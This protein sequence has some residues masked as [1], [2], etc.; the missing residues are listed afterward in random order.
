MFKKK[1]TL[2]TAIAFLSTALLVGCTNGGGGEDKPSGGDEPAVASKYTVNYYVDGAVYN[3]VNDVEK[4]SKLQAP[5]DPT[6]A[7]DEDYTYSFDGWYEN[8]STTKWN[9]E[10][11]TVTKNLDLYAKFNQSARAY[12]LV[13]WVWGGTTTVYITQDE[14][15]ALSTNATMFPALAQKQV[16]WK[17]VNNLTNPAFN[18]AVNNAHVSLVISG[19]KMDTDAEASIALDEEGAKA[20]VGFGWFNSVNRYVGIPTGLGNT[21]FA[22]AKSVYDVLKQ[23][24]PYYF[25][26]E[27]DTASLL[28]NGTAHLSAKDAD[29]NALTQ[30]LSFTSADPTIARV[31]E[32]GVVTGVAVGETTV[33]VHYGFAQRDFSVAVTDKE[34]NLKVAIWAKNGSNIYATE[35]QITAV[36]TGF[37]A[38]AEANGVEAV[39][40]FDYISGGTSVYADSI[41]NDV[42]VVLSGPNVVDQCG[43]LTAYPVIN[44]QFERARYFG[45]KEGFAADPVVLLFRDYLCQDTITV[46][47]PADLSAPDQEVTALGGET[48]NFPTLTP[49]EPQVHIGW[50]LTADATEALFGADAHPTYAQLKEHAVEGVVT[51][52]PVYSTQEINLKVAVWAVNG[53]NTYATD[54]EIAAVKTGFKAYAEAKGV[55][56]VSRFDAVSGGKNAYYANVPSDTMVILSGKNVID[57]CG[58]LTDYP[59]IHATFSSQRYFGIVSGF[60][61]NAI[62]QL[63]AEYLCQDTI[64]VKFPAELAAPDQEVTVLGEEKVVFPTVTPPTGQELKGWATSAS[65]TESEFGPTAELGYAELKDKAV[66]GVVTLYPIYGDIPAVQM[67]LVVDILLGTSDT[68]H[69]NEDDVALIQSTFQSALTAAGKTDVHFE[70]RADFRGGRNDFIARTNAAGDVDVVIG[71]SNVSGATNFPGLLDGTVATN[72]TIGIS[73]T[74]RYAFA[75]ADAE[76]HGHDDLAK[77]FLSAMHPEA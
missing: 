59:V 45:I 57:Q 66:E 30:G 9:F 35:E 24:G 64:T 7:Q 23:N 22:L 41:A 29:N 28:V 1:L 3:T 2:L 31:D 25:T 72:I 10:V 52:Y 61:T 34:V 12:D 21:E 8:G 74:D 43:T 17:Y 63:F 33:S 19:A 65:A 48:V 71:A 50:A 51:L 42:M 73:K 47:F 32:S 20:K 27:I 54:E 69:I 67:D 16:R 36:D 14:F 39:T 77:L 4:G 13:V 56:V 26:A 46:K 37:K 44:V 76:T 75:L 5:T 62:V 70:V 53:S 49:A 15:N 60:Q 55:D 11:D 58:T 6:K 40:R 38:Y 68:L 18:D